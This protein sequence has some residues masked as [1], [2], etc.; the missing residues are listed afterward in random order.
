[1]RIVAGPLRPFTHLRRRH[2]P[3]RCCPVRLT[4]RT[5]PRI[6]LAHQRRAAPVSVLIAAAYL[7]LA[8]RMGLWLCNRRFAPLAAMA[9]RRLCRRSLRARNKLTP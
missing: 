9:Q 5:H 3:L 1:M 4:L 8:A 6:A 7:R 2:A